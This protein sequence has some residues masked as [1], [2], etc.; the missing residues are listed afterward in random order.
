MWS[1]IHARGAGTGAGTGSRAAKDEAAVLAVSAHLTD[2]DRDL[3]RLVARHRVLTTGQLAALRFSNLTT[4]RHRLSA[5][6]RLGVLRRFRPH[7]ETGSAPWHYVLGPIGAALLG[8]EDRDEKKWAPQFRADRQLA[9]ERSQRLGHMTGASWFFVALAR[10][11][12][13]HGCGQLSRWDSERETA[14]FLYSHQSGIDSRPHP[15]GLGIWGEDS[16]DIVFLLEYDT[17]TEHL[18]QLAGKLPGYAEHA[19]RNIAFKAPILFC[20]PTLRREQ[21]ARKALTATRASRDLQIA[22]AA[23]DPRVTCPACGPAC[24]PLHGG[25]SPMRLID[26]A[27]VFPD[28]W[29]AARDQDERER[30]EEER[31][32]MDPDRQ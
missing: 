19:R 17:G 25:H 22:T 5:L 14:E 21:T 18:P 3:T 15:D 26:L 12:H 8:Q 6:V 7:R 1:H 20:F 32:E 16:R 24:M 29:R 31:R 28:P 30:C 4:A 13:E 23:L 27:D 11:A 9:L 2:R 10:H